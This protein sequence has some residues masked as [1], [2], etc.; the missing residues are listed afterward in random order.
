MTS[1]LDDH[2][3]FDRHQRGR[4]TVYSTSGHRTRPE[5]LC[6][7]HAKQVAD[8]AHHRTMLGLDVGLIGPKEP[9][10]STTIGNPHHGRCEACARQL[11]SNTRPLHQLDVP[12]R[13][14]PSRSP[15]SNQ[16]PRGLFQPPQHSS[17]PFKP[18]LPYNL[19][20]RQAVQSPP[21]G[22]TFEHGTEETGGSK[23]PTRN[24]IHAIVNDK[25]VGHITYLTHP[26]KR[27]LAIHMVHV[28]PSQRR[29][30]IASALMD[31]VQNRHP[32]HT[33]LHGDRTIDGRAWWSGYSQDKT[34]QR[35]RVT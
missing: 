10:E 14:A 1:P 12:D 22:M 17:E 33:I 28:L 21:E 31:E 20:A 30:G 15:Y 29:Q 8:Q 25:P 7:K 19:N 18:S 24:S 23:W 9:G 32:N 13:R 5:E 27:T 3:E 2:A 6:G 11:E 35:G 16:E 34:V 26:R 4:Q